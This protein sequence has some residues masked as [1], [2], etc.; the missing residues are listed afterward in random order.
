MIQAVLDWVP[1]VVGATTFFSIVVFAP[2]GIFRAIRAFA[3]FAL[4]FA[5]YIFALVLWF[6]GAVA[7]FTYWGW[8]GLI[9]GLVV[10]GVGVVPMGFVA[11]ALQA[12]WEWVGQLAVL[13]VSVSVSRL[14]GLWLIRKSEEETEA[15]EWT[16]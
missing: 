16:E 3:G 12:R 2:L 6:Y 4:V 9:I 1:I 13:L 5:S 7:T 15:H 8:A 14:L 10:F 11:L